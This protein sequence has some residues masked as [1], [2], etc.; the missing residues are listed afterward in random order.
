MIPHAARQHK[1]LVQALQRESTD[2]FSD[3]VKSVNVTGVQAGELLTT[4]ESALGSQVEGQIQRLEQEVAQLLRKSEELTSIAAMQ[5]HISFLK[6]FFTMSPLGQMG[7]TGDSVVQEDAVVASIR[8]VMKEL[9][10][11]IQ[12][13]CKESL[14]KITTLLNQNSSAS[15]SNGVETVSG[16]QADESCQA[17]FQNTVYETVTEPPPVPPARPEGAEPSNPT[18]PSSFHGASAPPLPIAP[19]H[20][21]GYSVST[22]GVVNPE[23]KTR[24]EMLKFRFEPTMDPNTAYRHVQLSDGGCKATLRAENMNPPDHPERFQFW[25]QV[26]CKQPL[27]GSPY[28]WEVEWTGQK[29]TIGVT[30]KEIERKGSDEKSRL[31]H[32]ANSWTLY[33][34]GS[35]FSF[36]HNS[37]EK[38][39]GSPKARRIGV[40]LDQQV[41]I[42]AFCSIANNKASLIHRHLTQFS[43][44]LYPGFR[45]WSGA[46]SAVTICQLD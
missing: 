39:L 41:G 4:H 26:L 28:Y 7:S 9:Q 12:D 36:W 13:R 6:N 11:G 37:Q 31:G 17:P 42:L 21:R 23:P 24:E 2:I 5:D 45:F 44:P 40:Y 3:L 34:S 35:G 1:A 16:A 46:G 25:R 38:L 15:A 8:S 20:P 27:G 22:V 30:Y 43:G 18:R 19:L 32:N 14:H 33:W 10:V 29:V